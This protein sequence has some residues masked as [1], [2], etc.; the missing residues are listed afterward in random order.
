M[1]EGL[2]ITPNERRPYIIKVFNFDKFKLR[3][4]FQ[5]EL[6]STHLKFAKALETPDTREGFR[7]E[8]HPLGGKDLKDL[9]LPEF[10]SLLL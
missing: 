6:K 10:C 8:V 4:L 9:K 3:R 5:L 1:G 7:V 2:C